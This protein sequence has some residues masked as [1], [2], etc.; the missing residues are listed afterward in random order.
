MRRIGKPIHFAGSS[1]ED[2]AHICAFFNSTEEAHRVLLPFIREGL[3]AGEKALHTIDP[4]KRDDHIRWLN[5][6]G[7]DV[8]AALNEERLEILDW[9]ESHLRSGEF[10]QQWTLA[11]RE[12]NAQA[13][14]RK[15][16]PVVRFVSETEWVLEADLDLNE[17][18]E[19]ETKGN[20]AWMRQD[21][22]VNPAICVYDRS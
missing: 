7:I 11:F 21:G 3:E 19:Y 18:L 10:D 14:K 6:A 13:A 5:S 22:P 17:L 20:D 12:K 15:G 8:V 2:R 1:L 4:K 16:F 9:T